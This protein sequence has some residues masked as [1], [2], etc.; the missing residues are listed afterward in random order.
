MSVLPS[1]SKLEA[2]V[3]KLTVEAQGALET[4]VVLPHEV[5]SLTAQAMFGGP[6]AQAILRCVVH[7][8][9]KIA[10]APRCER[11]LCGVCPRPVKAG[12]FAIAICKP[13]HADF[14]GAQ[15]LTFVICSRCGRGR[16]AVHEA[17]NVAL[18]RIWPH[19]RPITVTHADGGCA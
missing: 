11:M 12:K 6:E 17:A 2:A 18:R 19:S 10:T 3:D 7:T 9:S 8:L 13:M 1:T 4:L 14:D 15:V 16:P 5:P